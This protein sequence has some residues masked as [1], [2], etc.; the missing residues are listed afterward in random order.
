[1]HEY[2]SDIYKVRHTG[3]PSLCILGVATHGMPFNRKYVNIVLS[4][5]SLILKGLILKYWKGEKY[6]AFTEW[7]NLMLYQTDKGK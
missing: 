2:I 6:P 3:I 5:C 1:M 7:R 4:Y